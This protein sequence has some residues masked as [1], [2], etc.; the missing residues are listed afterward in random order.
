MNP[1][2]RFR[3]LWEL[4]AFQKS[5]T[6][7]LLPCIIWF[8]FRILRSHPHCILHPAR[9]EEMHGSARQSKPKKTCLDRISL[10]VRPTEVS[11]V[12]V[13]GRSP[14]LIDAQGYL[15]S[16]NLVKSRKG[17]IHETSRPGCFD[18]RSR[19]KHAHK[20]FANRRTVEPVNH[21]DWTLKF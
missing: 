5:Q 8:P 1:V 16:W 7:S 19:Q 12:C 15:E 6:S 20:N 9:C 21:R 3:A 4:V 17:K 13:I 18:E 11:N 2:I 14:L 10:R